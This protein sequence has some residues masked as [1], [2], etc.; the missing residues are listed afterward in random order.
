MSNISNAFLYFK[1]THFLFAHVLKKEY[2]CTVFNRAIKEMYQLG[3]D[4]GSTTIKM[5]LL[6]V[7]GD[8]VQ[9][10]KEVIATAYERHNAAPS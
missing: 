5:A 10:T 9:C 8:D 3:I 7:Q 6:D 2:F 1:E 4:I